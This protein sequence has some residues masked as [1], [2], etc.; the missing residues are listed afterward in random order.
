VY[1]NIRNIFPKSGTFLLG[2]PVCNKTSTNEILS[3]SN[4][5][6]RGVGPAKDL[7]APLYI[8]MKNKDKEWRRRK[9]IKSALTSG[10]KKSRVYFHP[11]LTSTH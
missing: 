6:Q 2:H 8:Y 5:I 3:P 10:E 1:F 11:A 9:N 4:K 7:S